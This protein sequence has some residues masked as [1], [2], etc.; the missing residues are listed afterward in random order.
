M[1]RPGE[2][3]VL[4]R[5]GRLEEWSLLVSLR[6]FQTSQGSKEADSTKQCLSPKHKLPVVWKHPWGREPRSGVSLEE[7][8]Y[9][10]GGKTLPREASSRRQEAW[11]LGYLSPRKSPQC[12]HLTAHPA[13]LGLGHGKISSCPSTV[14]LRRE[15]KKKN[16]RSECV[17]L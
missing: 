10:L 4:S 6:W 13:C 11:L 8:G 2:G 9:V 14:S 5:K 3:I 17:V 16:S 15:M 1:Q 12:F 7:N